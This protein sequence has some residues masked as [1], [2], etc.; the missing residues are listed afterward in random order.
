MIMNP[1]RN[2]IAAWGFSTWFALL[3]PGDRCLVGCF[4]DIPLSSLKRDAKMK[5]K[6]L[7]Q[8]NA[9]RSQKW[10][11]RPRRRHDPMLVFNMSVFNSAKVRDSIF[12]SLPLREN[13]WL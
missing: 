9:S 10:F 2:S 8:S 1:Q 12:D 13:A 6:D 11:H 4:R 7:K 3:S 5:T